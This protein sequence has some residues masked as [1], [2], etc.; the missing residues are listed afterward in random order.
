[1]NTACWSHVVATSLLLAGS[2]ACSSSPPSASLP[3]GS[4]GSGSPSS[5][6]STGGGATVAGAPSVA[7]ASA[8]GVAAGGNAS[9]GAGGVSSAGGSAGAAAPGVAIFP[10]DAVAAVSLTY[11]DG[12]DPHLAV[13]QP[14]L[15][16][17]GFRG[18]F[19]LS[20]FEGVD[21]DWALPNATLPLKPRH[22]AWQAAGAKG[23]ELAGH[24]V[25]HP[26]NAD[27]KAAGYHLTDYTMQRMSDELDDSLVRLKRLG[28]V[29]PLTFAY[30]CASDKAG[31]GAAA[32][33]YSPLVD[34]RFFAER[35][36][37]NGIADPKQV[38]L[39]RVPQLDTGGKT[40]DE[41]KTMVD[42]AI[43]AKGWLV[44]LFHGVGTETTCP[45]LDYAPDK[46]MINYL[47]TSTEA[48]AALVA[49][50]VEKKAQVWTAPFKEVA[51]RVMTKR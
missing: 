19:F 8:G 6:S 1:M 26:C 49:Y 46:C 34:A 20:N 23:H 25:N 4:G 15:E 21:H 29:A 5:G 7:G 32:Q 10:G 39:L 9:S 28:A 48:H 44:L 41:L 30:P 16:A 37:D 35:V 24:T 33:D 27:T 38:N 36:S 22:L 47:T 51:T 45:G 43:A 17:A 42:Q 2:W 40:G 12:L 11:D 18:T 3:G 13:V 31:I 14:A 50:L